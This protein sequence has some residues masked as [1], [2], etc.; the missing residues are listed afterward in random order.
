MSVRIAAYSAR[1][2]AGVISKPSTHGEV[3]HQLA[4]RARGDVGEDDVPG[5]I[6]RGDVMI[7][8]EL[9]HR[10][11]RAPPRSS[12]PRRLTSLMSST[13]SRSMSLAAPR[14]PCAVVVL[15]VVAEQEVEQRPATAW[16]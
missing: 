9:G 3:V 8:H 5:R 6:V 10:R 13:I 1:A 12:A 16:D 2:I 14:R 7:D 4:R 11:A 15:D